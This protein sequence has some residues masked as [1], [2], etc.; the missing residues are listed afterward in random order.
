MFYD[1]FYKKTQSSEKEVFIIKFLSWAAGRNIIDLNLL[2][3]EGS[4]VTIVVILF[5]KIS[6]FQEIAYFWI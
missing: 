6:Y 5:S 4:V 3:N 1:N 2:N